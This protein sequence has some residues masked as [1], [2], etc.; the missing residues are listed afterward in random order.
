M[1]LRYV[2]DGLAKLEC[3]LIVLQIREL[4]VRIFVAD[5]STSRCSSSCCN[6]L[7][8]AEDGKEELI[9]SH[10]SCQQIES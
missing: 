8:D 6:P 4:L 3:G 9:R 10:L 5:I 1:P 2:E 7:G